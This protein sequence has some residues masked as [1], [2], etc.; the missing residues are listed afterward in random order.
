M[1]R[2]EELDEDAR[3]QAALAA[4]GALPPAEAQAFEEHARQCPPCRVEYLSLKTVVAELALLAP[5]VAP[6]EN[7]WQRVA[8]RLHEPVPPGGAPGTHLNGAARA[9]SSAPRAAALRETQAWKRWAPDA[10]GAQP[11]AYVGAGDT[12]WEPT[13][14]AGIEARKLF[15]DA[16]HDRVTML[17]RM[18]AGSGYPAHVHATAEECFV[19]CGDLRTGTE[20]LREGDYQRAEPGSIHPVQVTD[21]GCILLLVSSLHDTLLPA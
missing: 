2:H 12:D 3:D 19:L 5:E 20:H 15:V 21:G 16:A 11:F 6:P 1:T 17:V 18:A 8:A 13:A 9:G 14:V 4:L 7:L 10:A